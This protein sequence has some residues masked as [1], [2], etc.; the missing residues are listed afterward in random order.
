MYFH[1]SMRHGGIV[2]WHLRL[3]KRQFYKRI[4]QRDLTFLLPTGL[5]MHVPRD[6]PAA[7][8]EYYS[9]ADVDWGSEALLARFASGDFIDAGAHV[10]YYSLYLAPLVE[11]VYAF[12]PDPRCFKG[13]QAN[14]RVA[15]N[16]S[17]IPKALS[18][19]S[20]TRMFDVS[21]ESPLNT[22]SNTGSLAVETITIDEFV[23]ELN[24]P[25]VGVIKTDVEGHDL[26][27]LEGAVNTL[28]KFQP[29]VLSE[30][31][32]GEVRDFARDIGFSTFAFDA[33]RRL[34]R[35]PDVGSKMVF[36]TPPRLVD[37]FESICRTN[38]LSGLSPGG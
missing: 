4:L 23:D 6:S 29:I 3:A 32:G 33:A 16:A 37:E 34:R 24:D 28:R 7:G 31:S 10:G 13:L 15:G 30:I 1:E 9:G 35:A 11:R 25:R 12:E 36:L 22:L 21:R 5:D 2:R 19:A 26:A 20:G 38:D 18:N 27:V 14:L 8:E 17:H